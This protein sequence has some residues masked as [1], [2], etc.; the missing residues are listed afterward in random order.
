PDALSRIEAGRDVYDLALSVGG[1]GGVAMVEAGRDVVLHL[2]GSDVSASNR[3]RIVG[4]GDPSRGNARGSDLYIVAGRGGG[5]DL[6]GF[7]AT[8]LDPENARGVVRTYLPELRDYMKKIGVEAPYDT[9]LVAAFRG[10]PAS[11]REVFLDRVFFTELRETGIDYNDA[12]GPRFHSYDRGFLATSLLFP[13]DPAT[14]PTGGLGSVLLDGKVVETQASGDINVLA[15]YGRIAVGTELTDP[16]GRGGI[17][18]RRGGSIRMMAD[19]NIDLFT[20]RVFT[21]QGGDILMWTSDGSI[22]AGA[23]SKTS[24]FYAPLRYT[25]SADGV[26][27]IDAFGLQTGAGIGVLDAL[28]NAGDRPRSRLDLIAPKGEV[29]AGDA[30]IRVVGDLNI[31]AQVVVGMENIQVS[32]SSQGVPKVDAPNIGALTSAS[33]VAQASTREG[34]GPEATARAR[35]ADLP[36][37]ITVEPVGYETKKEDEEAN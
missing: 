21:L 1:A 33:Q 31:A 7:A 8:Y 13:R 4:S 9:A 28:Q 2:S 3:G 22:T 37:L 5:V 11:R 19:Q 30:G 25:I 32:G 34:V 26:L 36:S 18:T 12:A 23:G 6:E 20:S 16:G 29:N 17:V 10:L 35:V 24:V 15:P 14:T 27:Q